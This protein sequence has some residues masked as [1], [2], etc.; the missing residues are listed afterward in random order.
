MAKESVIVGIDIGSSA[1]RTVV[2]KFEHGATARPQVIGLGSAPSIGIR[3]GVIVD[4][5]E[6]VRAIRASKEQAERSSGVR[7]E[8]AYLSVGGTHI[9]A[10]LS[11]GV[12]AVSRAD[13]EITEED[14]T[15]AINAASAI[16]LPQNREIIHVVPRSFSVDSEGGIFDPVG[17]QGIRLEV[18][19]LI[20]EGSTPLLK[21]LAKCLAEAAV[22]VLD[23]VLDS[24]AA[25]RATLSKRQREIGV[26]LLDIGGSSTDLAVFEEGNVLHAGVVPVG[27]AHITNDLAIGLK[28]DVEIAERI[29]VE[30][31]SCLPDEV[32]KKDFVELAKISPEEAG[33]FSRREVAEIIEARVREIFSLAIK[34]LKLIQRD[35]MLPGGAA[36]VGG[37]AKIPGIVDLAKE[38]LNIPVHIGFP[39]DVDGI[40]EAVDDPIFAT[41]VGLVL[42]GQDL[43]ERKKS[44]I[45]SLLSGSSRSGKTTTSRLKKFFKTFIPAHHGM[46]RPRPA[47]G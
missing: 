18:D 20:V 6:T 8:N 27:A 15:R 44:G 24:L 41:A 25:S 12:V 7:I 17:M 28:T 38:E 42:W 11:K 10:R 22:E 40:V 34:E 35:K 23:V 29:K 16:S 3:R 2:A 47:R 4:L 30:Y 1:I 14:V 5:E 13:G 32:P 33:A 43:E 26:L 39:R 37:G 36:L 9:N 46:L 45:V 21:N 19:A 31:G